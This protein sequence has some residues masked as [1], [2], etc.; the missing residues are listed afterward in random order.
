MGLMPR[1]FVAQ[2]ALDRW[3]SAGG[4]SLEA[5][6]MKLSAVPGVNFY[7]NPGVHFV[8]LD[9]GGTDP[10]DIIGSVKTSHELAQLG[11]D[12]YDASVIIGDSAYSVRP[13]FVGTPIGPDGTEASLDGGTWGAVLAAI[14]AQGY[15]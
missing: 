3:M 7:I 11:G 6:L 9:G 8:S 14:E 15:S 1:I 10:Y 12:H 5:D 4:A 13:G 2:S